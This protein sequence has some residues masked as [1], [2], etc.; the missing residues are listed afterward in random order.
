MTSDL[1]NVG[2]VAEYGSL[3]L[4]MVCFRPTYESR[5]GGASLQPIA[6]RTS[7]HW[8][9]IRYSAAAAD[10][11]WF[12]CEAAGDAPGFGGCSE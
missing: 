1:D 2:L 10:A 3:A 5:E 4:P 9:V 6:A 8:P 7:A 12:V 11:P